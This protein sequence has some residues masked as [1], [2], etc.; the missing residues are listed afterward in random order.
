MK[1]TAVTPCDCSDHAMVHV[2]DPVGIERLEVKVDIATAQSIAAQLH[3]IHGPDSCHSDLLDVC[4]AS[5]G[6]RLQGVMLTERPGA[7]YHAH[8]CVD[9]VRAARVRV[10][11]GTALVVAS[12]LALPVWLREAP[13]ERSPMPAAYLR[14]FPE[15]GEDD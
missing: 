14:A 11:L 10:P 3:G 5:Q 6:A 12:R 9:G 7:P 1:V 2:R 13:P 4:L 15:E 8:F